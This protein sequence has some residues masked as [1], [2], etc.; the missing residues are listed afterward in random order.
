M[1]TICTGKLVY[2]FLI[3]KYLS[4]SPYIYNRFF[5]PRKSSVHLESLDTVIFMQ[6]GT[7]L[8][9]RVAFW[10]IVIIQEPPNCFMHH[11]LRKIYLMAQIATDRILKVYMVYIPMQRKAVLICQ[12]PVAILTLYSCEKICANSIH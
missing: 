11:V 1:C 4:I 5:T 8:S 3:I 10:I 12:Q 9:S 2:E 6:T 7:V